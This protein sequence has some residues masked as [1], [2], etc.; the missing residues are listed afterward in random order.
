MNPLIAW[1]GEHLQGVI[2]TIALVVA[3]LVEIPPQR[4]LEK[5]LE[6]EEIIASK[7]FKPLLDILQLKYRDD[8]AVKLVNRGIGPAIVNDISFSSNQVLSFIMTINEVQ[9]DSTYFVWRA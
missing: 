5:Q 2:A 1:F 7:N 8:K 3:I 4:R 9:N 6:R